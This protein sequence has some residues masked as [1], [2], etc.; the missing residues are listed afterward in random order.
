MT[1]RDFLIQQYDYV[2][3]ADLR[4]LDAA[5]SVPSGRWDEDHGFS[6]GTVHKTLLH[7]IG[8]QHVWVGRWSGDSSRAFP[9]VE[10]L[11]TIEAIRT[12]WNAV[13]D[14]LLGYVAKQTDASLERRIDY[15][16]NNIPHSNVLWHAIAHCAD[17]SNY[18]RGQ[19]NSLIK[20]SGGTPAGTMYID[21][22]RT[23]EGQI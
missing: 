13:H 5:A 9:T 19:L 16:R 10:E 21:W 11:P 14:E 12:R 17:H 1:T 6:F 7:M 4:N 8:A 22:R 20:L 2:K 18:H 15:L 3:W 23:Q